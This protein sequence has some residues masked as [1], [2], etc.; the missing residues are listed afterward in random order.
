MTQLHLSNARPIYAPSRRR[1]IATAA[2]YIGPTF[3]IFTMILMVCLISVV[4]LMFSTR[5]I[6]KGYALKKLEAEHEQLLRDHE[7]KTMHVAEVRSL[8]SI[9]NSP[10]VQAMVRPKQIVYYRGDTA[11]A[12]K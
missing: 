6:T 11:I 9:K 10:K 2:F 12:S 5:E 4:T 1:T 8:M 3:L 7:A